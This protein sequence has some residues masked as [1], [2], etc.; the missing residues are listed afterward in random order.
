RVARRFADQTVD[1]FW[2]AHGLLARLSCPMAMVVVWR[3]A[4]VD[5]CRNQGR[6]LF[7]RQTLSL[8]RGFAAAGGARLGRTPAAGIGPQCRRGAQIPPHLVA[9]S[10]DSR[11]HA[12][13]VDNRRCVRAARSS[14]ARIVVVSPSRCDARNDCAR[15]S[16]LPPFRPFW[17]SA[18]T[19]ERILLA[20]RG[21]MVD[22]A[23]G[24]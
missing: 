15:D 21:G 16:R 18:Q 22:H 8:G 10:R 24:W 17:I 13:A 23:G 5:A 4:R 14:A 19:C 12:R 11:E 7:S 2:S 1:L 6:R 20:S 9:L 3:L